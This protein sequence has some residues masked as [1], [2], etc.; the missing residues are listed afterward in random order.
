MQF[1]FIIFLGI[2]AYIA[3][4]VSQEMTLSGSKNGCLIAILG[5]YASIVGGV[6]IVAFSAIIFEFIFG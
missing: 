3:Y 4:S 6:F 2:S 1:T 5:L